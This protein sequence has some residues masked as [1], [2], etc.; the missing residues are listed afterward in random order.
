MYPTTDPFRLVLNPADYIANTDTGQTLH[1]IL[2][3]EQLTLESQFVQGVLHLKPGLN[4][5]W[6]LER[7]AT[8]QL[9]MADIMDSIGQAVSA[10]FP[11]E[12][13]VTFAAFGFDLDWVRSHM[14]GDG[15]GYLPCHTG[16]QLLRLSAALDKA[17]LARIRR[18][19][20]VYT[21]IPSI[22]L[23]Q[24]PRLTVVRAA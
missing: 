21:L 7:L 8:R 11:E 5:H 1:G 13:P 6:L 10:L 17:A 18:N 20:A 12:H 24:R 14:I 2:E 22:N 19:P 4:P 9:R 15:A 16:R 23:V 3:L